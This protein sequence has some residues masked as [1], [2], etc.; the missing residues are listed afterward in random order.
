MPNFN[1]TDAS[2]LRCIVGHVGKNPEMQHTA[3]GKRV[4]KFTVAT[5]FKDHNG[6]V[7]TTWHHVNAWEQQ[8]DEA[9]QLKK[10]QVVCVVGKE[11]SREYNG[12]NF[13]DLS[14][15]FVGVGLRVPAANNGQHE[16]LPN[17]PQKQPAGENEIPF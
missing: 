11:S 16:T 9:M 7:D 1:L 13:T 3:T 8:A 15:W 10:G 17:N 12:K 14:A 4:A 6:K 2:G 5:N